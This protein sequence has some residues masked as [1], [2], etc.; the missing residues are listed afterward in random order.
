[1]R[2]PFS[3]SFPIGRLFGIVIRIHILLVVIFLAFYIRAVKEGP[4]GAGLDM[5]YVLAIIFLSVLLHEFGHCYGAHLMEGEA[6]QILLWPLGGLAFVDVPHTPRANFITVLLGPTV[7]LI[8]CIISGAALATVSLVPPFNPIW[9]F[10]SAPL[11]HWN[12]H[13]DLVNDRYITTGFFLE[14]WQILAARVFWINWCQFLLNVF[15]FA[16][17]LDGGRLL[18]AALWPRMGYHRAT[19]TAIYIGFI[20]MFLFAIAAL[21][22]NEVLLLGMALFIFAACRQQYLLLETG[23]EEGVF[24][25]DF[26]Q[27]YTSLE[28]DDEGATPAPQRKKTNF[29]QRWL[30][31]R[32]LRKFQR[33]Q[34]RREADEQRMD[35]LLEKIQRHGRQSLTDEENRFMKRVADRYRNRS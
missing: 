27:G 34:E 6:Q 8:L 5:L 20:F 3:W 28:R 11:Y 4:P 14:N 26:S 13:A 18:Q 10:F 22:V 32:A 17:P 29:I 7:N 2:D 24:G 12:L 21:A 33:E 19:Y 30:K 25:Y 35:Q 31:R 16:Y 1:M 15:V 23:G 9:N